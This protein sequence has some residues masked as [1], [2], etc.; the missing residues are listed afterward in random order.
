MFEKIT[1]VKPHLKQHMIDNPTLYPIR[2]AYA[3]LNRPKIVPILKKL[4]SKEMVNLPEQHY[5]GLYTSVLEN[6]ADFV[7]GLPAIK[8]KSHNYHCGL[9][10]LGIQRTFKAL[11]SYRI[12]H[13]V[14]H[15]EPEKVP[16]QLSRWTYAL[17]T[18]ALFYGLGQVEAIYW[19]GVSDQ[20]GQHSTRWRPLAEPIRDLGTHYRYTYEAISQDDLAARATP[21][22]A[23]QLMPAEGFAWIASDQEIFAFWLAILQNDERASGFL[24]KHLMEAEEQL[25][26]E[27]GYSAALFPSEQDDQHLTENK[28]EEDDDHGLE[29]NKEKEEVSVTEEQPKSTD[30]LQDALAEKTALDVS[31]GHILEIGEHFIHWLRN[32]VIGHGASIYRTQ[33]GQLFIDSDAFQAFIRDNPQYKNWQTVFRQVDQQHGIGG[34]QRFQQ[35]TTPQQHQTLSSLT[36]QQKTIGAVVDPSV[37]FNG[38]TIPAHVQ[39]LAANIRVNVNTGKGLPALNIQPAAPIKKA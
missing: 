25:L 33:E 7:Q 21:L 5:Q 34:N 18:A 26:T 2:S 22:I 19:V 38:H 3:L 28:E 1:Q 12:E 24:I 9:L 36:H 30:R 29:K 27:S 20:K 16:P 23:K 17:F 4:P 13:P 11:Q 8:F 37:I 35:Y 14:R 39:A 10:E 6:Y 32:A 31:G 15:L